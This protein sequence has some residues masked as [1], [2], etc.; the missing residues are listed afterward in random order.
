MERYRLGPVIME[1]EN[2]LDVIIQEPVGSHTEGMEHF[3][4]ILSFNLRDFILKT[5]DQ[6]V[7]FAM[8]ESWHH[9]GPSF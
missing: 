5:D 4:F 9:L 3:T 7:Y 8:E 2:P 6:M 1:R